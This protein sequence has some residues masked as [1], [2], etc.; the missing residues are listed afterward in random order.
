MRALI[1]LLAA[2]EQPEMVAGRLELRGGVSSLDSAIQAIEG[3]A[4]AGYSVPM[5][6]GS[7]H[8][9]G[10]GEIV[11]LGNDSVMNTRPEQ[12]ASRTLFVLYRIANRRVAEIRLLS[13]GCRIDAGSRSLYW[14]EPVPPGESLRQLHA[15]ASS[16]ADEEL[17]EDAVHAIALHFDSHANEILD[18]LASSAPSREV[19]ERAIFWLGAARGDE[20]YRKLSA[21]YEREGDSKLREEIVFAIHLSDAEGAIEKLVAIARRDRDA[22]VRER[23]LF[24]LSQK[25][26]EVAAR[27]IATAVKE[28]PDLEVKKQAVFALSQLPPEEGVPLL[29]EVAETHPH[30]EVKKQAFFW[31]G[32]SDDPR[33]IDLFEKVLLRK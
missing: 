29:V 24:W 20:G 3:P 14:W 11:R 23:A 25:A 1:L 7:H 26:G 6:P 4:W 18:E 2:L 19:R 31:L 10:S 21:R 32:Q 27:A 8:F 22:D 30:P 33:A 16:A 28:D 9:C 15:L 13:T 5:I 17:A 12:A